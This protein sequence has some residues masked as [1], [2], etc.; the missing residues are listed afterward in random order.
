M[1]RIVLGGDD[2]T[3]I[4]E[5]TDEL[6][7]LCI[8]QLSG[9]HL[10]RSCRKGWENGGDMYDAI[11]SGRVRSTPGELKEREGE[12]AKKSRSYALNRLEKGVDWRKKADFQ[13]PEG[14]RGLGGIEGNESH[15]FADRMKDRGMSWTIA[16]AVYMGKAIQLA[17]NEELERWCGCKPLNYVN[18]GVKKNTLSFDLFD[19]LDGYGKR[20]GLPALEGPHASRPWARVLKGMTS[21]YNP[22]N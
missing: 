13:I 1:K 9:F 8:R 5:G 22:L 12:T 20:T 7:S 2:A 18:S 11:R 10:S 4:D 21:P 15:L 6:G 17:F 14:A 19:E 16:G 3:W